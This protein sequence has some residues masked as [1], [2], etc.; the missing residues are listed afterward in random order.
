MPYCGWDFINYTTSHLTDEVID[1]LRKRL[2]APYLYLR[3]NETIMDIHIPTSQ[4]GEKLKELGEIFNGQLITIG[5]R[6]SY[7]TEIAILSNVTEEGNIYIEYIPGAMKG[8]NS[9]FMIPS[10]L[11]ITP[12]GKII[13]EQKVEHDFYYKFD[14]ELIDLVVCHETI[15]VELNPEEIKQLIE[16]TLILQEK[17]QQNVIIEWWKWQDW[18][19]ANDTSL[20]NNHQ[21]QVGESSQHWRVVSPGE[22]TGKVLRIDQFDP[23]EIAYL[24]HGRGL[25]VMKSEEDDEFDFDYLRQLRKQIQEMKMNGDKVLVY[26]S[27]PYLYFVPLS[28]MVDGFI[29]ESAS[30]LCHFSIILREMKVPAIA[31]QGGKWD[32]QTG[33]LFSYASVVGWLGGQ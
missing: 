2:R 9:G 24:S 10:S 13:Q 19:L 15:Q 29:F 5:I 30:L 3:V 1:E 11:L 28:E 8:I 33:D 17:M 31:L 23:E 14:E 22:V 7:P 27:K 21:L 25:S 12:E 4:L 18:I 26:L 16:R 6:E 20:L 32:G